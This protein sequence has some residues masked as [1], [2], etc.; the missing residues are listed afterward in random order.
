MGNE[1]GGDVA[2]SERRCMGKLRVM[3]ARSCHEVQGAAPA[4]EAAAAAAPRREIG[5]SS[6][7]K[8]LLSG[9]RPTTSYEWVENVKERLRLADEWDSTP[10]CVEPVNSSTADPRDR[11]TRPP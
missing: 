6:G 11:S 7:C 4:G 8:T 3:S 10:F 1:M 9:T 2:S 5:T